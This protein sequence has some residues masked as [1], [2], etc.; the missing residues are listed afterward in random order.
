MTYPPPP[1]LQS[2]AELNEAFGRFLTRPA[3]S[4]ATPL[5]GLKGI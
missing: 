2:L 4:H 3:L 1:Y 5:V